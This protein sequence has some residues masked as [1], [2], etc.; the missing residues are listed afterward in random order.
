MNLPN[1]LENFQVWTDE[2]E[3]SKTVSPALNSE[4]KA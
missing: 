4:I 3:E 2:I 1:T